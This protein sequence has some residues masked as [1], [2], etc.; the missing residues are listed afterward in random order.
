VALPS[1]PSPSSSGAPPPEPG[2]SIF[3]IGELISG[4]YEIRSIL[5]AGGMGQVFEAHD[6]LLNRR[7]AIKAAW[8]GQDDPVRKEA[9]ALAAVRHPSM[10]TVYTVGNHEGIEYVV[11]ERVYGVSLES[12]LNKKRAMSERL[13]VGEALDLMIA[14]GEGLDAVH[15]AGIAH[16]DVKPGNIMIAPGN[17]VVLMDFGLFLPEFDVSGQTMVAGSPEYMAPEAIENQIEPG[18]GALVDLY[19]FGVLGFQLLAGHPPYEA[20]DVQEVWGKHLYSDIPDVRAERGDVPQALAE[21]LSEMMAKHA[22]ERPQSVDAVLWQLRRIQSQKDARLDD[23]SFSVLVVD[24][25]REVARVLGHYVKKAVPEA[26]VRT[27]YD[28][29]TAI[30]AVREREPDLMLLDL[31]MPRMNG[32][33]VCMYLRG[34]RLAERCTIG[35]VSAG[36]QEQDLALLRQL[37]LTHFLGKGPRLADDVAGLVREVRKHSPASMRPPRR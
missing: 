1:S 32:I 9:Q 24:D 20:E 22:H 29:D 5:G 18:A 28:G 19:A 12:Y 14:I 30:D 34:A 2:A 36:A 37:G 23:A 27:V 21:L 7:V 8:A 25:D 17:R 13:S 3:E 4:M 33:E 11:M 26:D 15:R 31:Q 16:R 35:M 6:T 10:V